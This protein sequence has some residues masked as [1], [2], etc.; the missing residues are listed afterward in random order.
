M[1]IP[2]LSHC[3]LCSTFLVFFFGGGGVKALKGREREREKV[4]KFIPK[5]YE[6]VWSLFNFKAGF[7]IIQPALDDHPVQN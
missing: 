7:C 6:L 2:Y 4:D 3:F 5:I 1:L